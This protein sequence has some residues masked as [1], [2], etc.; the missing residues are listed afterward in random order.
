M[1]IRVA[2]FAYARRALRF[3]AQHNA[4]ILKYQNQISSGLSFER[5][6]DQP[7]GYQQVASLRARFTELTAD[8]NSIDRATSVLNASVDQLESFNLAITKAKSL[9][10]QGIQALDNDEREALALEIDG[11]ISHVKGITLS[12]FDEKY[13]FGGTKSNDPPFDFGT[14]DLTSG[15]I[16]AT[17]AGSDNRSRASVGESIAVDVYY[18]GAEIFSGLGREDTYLIGT[19]GAKTGLGTDTLTGRAQLEVIHDT[20]SYAGASGIQVGTSSAGSDTII[21]AL[22]DHQLTIVDTAGDGSAGT[23]S[24]NGGPA[25]AFTN[26][27][28]DLRVEGSLGQAVH[29]DTTAIT[30]GFN[31]TIDIESTG[32]LSVDGGDSLTAIDF[33]D[34]QVVT[35]SETG[36]FVTIDSRNIGSTGTEELEFLGTT[37]AVELLAEIAADLR[38][39]RGLTSHQQSESLDRRL[40]ELSSIAEKSLAVIG[41]QATSLRTMDTLGTTS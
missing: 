36:K 28:T 37:N 40:G 24:L 33:S 4:S 35:D 18:S 3:T 20:T 25:V 2:S 17:Y 27:D 16:N 23:I 34:N 21:G 1:T 12:R 15:S 26:A 13:L 9:T 6:S 22:G 5:P 14:T 8:R 10:Q 38:N 11:L 29:V 19:T 30:A 39:T 32:Q 31:G 7:I 41:E